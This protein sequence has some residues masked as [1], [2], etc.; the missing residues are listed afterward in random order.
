LL[1][2]FCF[3][4]LTVVYALNRRTP[5]QKLWTIDPAK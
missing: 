2:I 1:L 3:A 4:V 5:N